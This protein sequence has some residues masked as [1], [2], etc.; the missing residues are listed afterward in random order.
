MIEY[1]LDSDALIVLSTGRDQRHEGVWR[2]SQ[3]KQLASC[4]ITEGALTRYLIRLKESPEAAIDTLKAFHET[5]SHH[6]VPDSLPYSL[7]N[8]S[9]VLGHKQVTDAYLVSLAKSLNVRLATL[10][11]GLAQLYP[12]D[13]ELINWRAF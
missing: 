7:A 8:M 4:P 11:E 9:S 6:F 12:N 3:G 10:D 5:D 2:W 1:L 13:A